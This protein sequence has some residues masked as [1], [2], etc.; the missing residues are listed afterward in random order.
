MEVVQSHCCGLAIPTRVIM[1]CLLTPKPDGGVQQEIRQFRTMTR[2]MQAMGDWLAQAGCTH[3]AMERTGVY[4]K[5]IWNLLEERFSLLLVNAQQIKQVP[6]RKRDV[7]DCAWI[8]DLL[9]HGVLRASYV[10]ERERTAEVNRLEQMLEGAN[11]KRSAVASEVLGTSG[12]HTIEALI[13]GEDDPAVL[14]DLA[15]GQLGKK[16]VALEEALAGLIGAHQRFL[17]AQQLGQ[18]DALSAQIE[19]LRREIGER[20]RPVEAM[21]VRLDAIP[22]IG[23]WSAEVLLAEIGTDLTRFPTAA[24]LASWAGM[25]PGNDE[26]AGKRRSGRTRHGDAVLTVTLTEAAYAAGRSKDTW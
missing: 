25:S 9:R 22:G 23:R 8:A 1:A 11:I 24:H 4:C 26:S 17:L 18:I 7:R 5:P 19:T 2:D 13:A 10:P 12:R 3:L 21:I 16:L 6:G 20:L 15:L 14:A